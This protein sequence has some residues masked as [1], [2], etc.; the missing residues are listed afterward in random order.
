MKKLYKQVILQASEEYD[1]LWVLGKVQEECAELIAAINKY[2]MYMDEKSVEHI[3]EELV[4]TEM[5]L[6]IFKKSA[7]DPKGFLK[8]YNKY[9]DKKY[10]RLRRRINKLKEN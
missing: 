6:K 8:L 7:K 4:D 2:R 3:I 1:P 5:F 9:K 10:K